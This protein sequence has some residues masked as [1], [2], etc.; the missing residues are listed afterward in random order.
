MKLKKYPWGEFV[1]IND[2]TN[3]TEI[4]DKYKN[5]SFALSLT[6]ELSKKTLDYFVKE[7]RNIKILHLT[8]E[9]EGELSFLYSLN[10]LE[11]FVLHLYA[12]MDI[13]IDFL[14]ISPLRKLG[15]NW[16][17]KYF[18]NLHSQTSLEHLSISDFT[19]KDFKRIPKFDKLKS[20]RSI[21][22]KLKTLDNIDCI[23]NI[24]ALEISAHRSLHDFSEIKHLKNLK[25][26]ELNS[27]WQVVDLSPLA[28]LK[29]L[30][31]VKIIDCKNLASI[32]FAK[33]LPKL[34]QL[35][36]LGTTIINDF[37]TTP[38]EKVPI[39]FGSRASSKY[40]K[41]YP[42]KEIQE[43]QKTWNSYLYESRVEKH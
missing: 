16:Y 29:Q 39:F 17:Y 6:G 30:E 32:K 33:D 4:D 34:R 37:D 21:G 12:K 2:D 5:G 13:T 14:K 28:G 1:E 38:A 7:F 36:T 24:V 43:G 19:E 8:N 27:C 26:I 18:Q 20:F 40:N 22:G 42:E 11:E 41:E 31:V 3:F 10:R 15:M 25:F 9:N 35:Y 23:E